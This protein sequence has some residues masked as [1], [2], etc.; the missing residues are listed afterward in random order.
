ML[1]I[2]EPFDDSVG[3]EPTL[4]L[5]NQLSPYRR[6]QINL[7]GRPRKP[8]AE[9]ESVLLTILEGDPD[10]AATLMRDHVFIQGEVF[11]DPVSTLLPSYVATGTG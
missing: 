2:L 5:R 3:K 7:A 9:H 1:P 8:F 10:K 4:A 11:T 6:F